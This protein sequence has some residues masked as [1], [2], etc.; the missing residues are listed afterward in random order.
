MTF[1]SAQ[2]RLGQTRGSSTSPSGPPPS[3]PAHDPSGP[4]W[5]RWRTAPSASSAVARRTRTR[6]G[7]RPEHPRRPPARGWRRAAG[8]A[9]GWRS[10]CGTPVRGGQVTQQGSQLGFVDADEVGLGADGVGQALDLGS[11][12]RAVDRHRGGVVSCEDLVTARDDADRGRRR[13]CGH[14]VRQIGFGG[15]VDAGGRLPLG[16]E[17]GDDGPAQHQCLEHL[18]RV[19][20]SVDGDDRDHRLVLRR[21][22]ERERGDRRFP[23]LVPREL[24][25]RLLHVAA[26]READE[27]RQAVDLG[28]ELDIGKGHRCTDRGQVP[29]ADLHLVDGAGDEGPLDL[30]RPRP[31]LG[32]DSTTR[33]LGDEVVG[34]WRRGRSG[35]GATRAS[36]PRPRAR[37][38]DPSR[39]SPSD[40]SGRGGAAGGAGGGGAAGG[41]GGAAT[42]GGAADSSGADQRAMSS[43]VAWAVTS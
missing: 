42:G 39:T 37:G 23:S 32:L 11:E 34:R 14:Q 2:N 26:P 18:G 7:G 17:V 43:S 27:E 22:F 28:R 1:D 30:R 33:L 31:H 40:G 6:V 29:D 38:P 12:R 16:G 19:V 5:S 10:G 15:Q 8:R 25:H 24:D 35:A 41:E 20:L 36:R 3:H 13:K 4:P 21:R 9:G